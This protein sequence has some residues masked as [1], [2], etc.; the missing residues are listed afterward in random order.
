M[1]KVSKL[2]GYKT[3]GILMRQLIVGQ[4]GCINEAVDEL[5]GLTRKYN[6]A[7]NEVGG[8]RQTL[9]EIKRLFV[10]IGPLECDWAQSQTLERGGV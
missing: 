1:W 5:E 9:T 6:V 7:L 4:D 10:D 8:Q 2:V 3:L